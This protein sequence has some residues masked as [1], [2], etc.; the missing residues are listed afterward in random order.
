MVARA[1][2]LIKNSLA[3]SDVVGFSFV[4]CTVGNTDNEKKNK[5]NDLKTAPV[6]CEIPEAADNWLVSR[7][8]GAVDVKKDSVDFDSY[9]LDENSPRS[10]DCLP[11]Y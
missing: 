8:S 1:E 3:A 10:S 7:A 2:K 11:D 4:K 6:S 5:K 9:N